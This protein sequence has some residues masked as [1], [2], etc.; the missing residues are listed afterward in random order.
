MSD[1]Q[2][3]TEQVSNLG[4]NLR[5]IPDRLEPGKWRRLVNV[6]SDEEGAL[7]TRPG[8][9]LLC[10]G[11]Y[12][13]VH[14][15]VKLEDAIIYGIGTQMLRNNT[16]YASTWHDMPKTTV[17]HK[18]GI[19]EDKWLYISDAYNHKMLNA[20]GKEY[21]W[22][23]DK[24][25]VPIVATV[26]NAAGGLNSTGVNVYDWR[27][28]YYSTI[29]G[30]ESNPS[31]EMSAG[32]AVTLKTVFLACEASTDPQVDRIRIYRR[33]GSL[34]QLGW[35]LVGT[36]QNIPGSLCGF[37]D[38]KS[39][40][41]I[42]SEKDLL[43][44]NDRPFV[45]IVDNPTGQDDE[46]IGVPMPYIFGP[47]IGKYILGCGDRNRPNHVYWTNPGRPTSAG[48]LN[49]IA[50]TG[51]D[52]PLIGGF[53]YGG[54]PYVYSREGFYALDF[55][56]DDSIPVFTVR[57]LPIGRGVSAPYALC[58][59]MTVFF[60]SKDGIYMG[61]MQGPAEPLTEKDIRPLFLPN[62]SNYSASANGIK[63]IDWGAYSPNPPNPLD[64]ESV[65]NK[66]R[67]SWG[68][69]LLRLQYIASD[70]T[71]VHL[72]NDTPYDRWS[73]DELSNPEDATE[74]EYE[75]IAYYDEEQP[76]TSWLIG[77]TRGKILIE[78]GTNDIGTNI[79]CKV[80][81]RSI[82]FDMPQTY[83]ELGNIILDID[84]TS[85]YV[86]EYTMP[87]IPG[88]RVTPYY[89]AET[90]AGS[91]QTITGSGRKKHPLSLS[92]EYVY[93]VAVDLEWWGQAKIYQ[94]DLL[95]RMDEELLTHWEFPPTTFGAK[96]WTHM[97]DFYLTLRSIGT[98]NIIVE[99]DGVDYL[100]A[101]AGAGTGSIPSTAG[102]KTKFHLWMPPVKGKLYRV[103][104]YNGPFRLYGEDS[105]MRVKEW[106]TG[107]VYPT[108]NPFQ[109]EGGGS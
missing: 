62:Q 85:A 59:G 4:L 34:G 27:F 5:D 93:S 97:R 89:N 12:G 2:N 58:V 14:T 96:G 108:V 49:H 24:P 81:S 92:D 6:R 99:V 28:T 87:P 80:R 94:W 66:M 38:A 91:F 84:A 103:I 55:Q 1:Y 102:A 70:S 52:E 57:K 22:G 32:V 35:K 107:L 69:K 75:C 36:I 73:S 33:G 86:P 95:W 40:E 60:L 41:E 45:S 21:T 17:R 61:D 51:P 104:L 43:L 50:V 68:G 47:F 54:L 100:P 44:D 19:G 11:R 74:T 48:A 106:A 72:V 83:K 31:K 9:E 37:D 76:N 88:L 7:T 30:A 13:I 20:K 18:A 109:A 8:R 63:Q 26:T 39:D 15:L 77:T 67:M 16:P 56:G 64:E 90:T 82:D 98:V 53:I 101:I 71:W 65:L 29:T 3:Y 79:K 10:S 23:I 25:T 105:E 78:R 42:L 46:L